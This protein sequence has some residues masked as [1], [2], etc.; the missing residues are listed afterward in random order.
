MSLRTRSEIIPLTL[1]VYKP[2]ETK[3]SPFDTI[4]YIFN[5]NEK[6]LVEI[7]RIGKT[8]ISDIYTI[9]KLFYLTKVKTD[10]LR[11]FDGQYV[12][13]ENETVFHFLPL[14]YESVRYPTLTFEIFNRNAPTFRTI[15]KDVNVN[16]NRHLVRCID[17]EI[18][19]SSSKTK[20]TTYNYLFQNVKPF[21][22]DN[23]QL[24]LDEDFQHHLYYEDGVT[25]LPNIKITCTLP[26]FQL[27]AIMHRSA[28]YGYN[29]ELLAMKIDNTFYRF[30]YGNIYQSDQMCFGINSNRVEIEPP[31]I[32]EAC[33]S[34]I[35][36]SNFNG[37]FTP[38]I[39]F[40]NT[41]Q[42]SLDIEYVREKISRDDFSISFI[43]VLLYLSSCK[44]PSDVNL[45]LFLQSPNVPDLNKKEES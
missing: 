35:I 27:Y 42:I 34:H 2:V 3:N 19:E 15:N 11:T 26:V 5:N 29:C 25:L 16:G 23:F 43:D 31:S 22:T 4:V 40:D 37:D 10:W 36:T 32:A 14:F 1:N 17:N 33:Y 39:N 13:F 7:P 24:E 28:S 18:I 41:V 30:P 45:N 21:Q 12:K 6:F 9:Q 20:E 38:M 8:V 44:D